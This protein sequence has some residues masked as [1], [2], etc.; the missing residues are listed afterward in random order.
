MV[1]A[2]LALG[3]FATAT[4]AT[5][6]VFATPAAIPWAFLVA[7]FVACAGCAAVAFWLGASV[8]RS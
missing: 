5:V 2:S 8:G 3:A 6:L 4:A 7:C 1:A